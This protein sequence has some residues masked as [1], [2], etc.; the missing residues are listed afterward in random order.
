[1]G[2]SR[3]C[4]RQCK[5][6]CHGSRGSIPHTPTSCGWP[7]C[8]VPSCCRLTPLSRWKPHSTSWSRNFA[9]RRRGGC[10]AG[11]RTGV[12][13]APEGRR[14]GVDRCGGRHPRCPPAIHRFPR[15]RAIS[16]RCSKPRPGPGAPAEAI[17]EFLR[18]ARCGL[19][20]TCLPATSA[21]TPSS[22]REGRVGICRSGQ[23][24]PVAAM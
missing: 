13:A 22:H 10:A 5:R 9:P 7:T 12:R 6:T 18:S 2:R 15:D 21:T 19:A 17:A 11:G 4:S 8:Q 23:S 3:T 20:S 1:M 16:S 24:W 14:G